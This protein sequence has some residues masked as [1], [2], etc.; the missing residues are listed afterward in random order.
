MHWA[1]V[2]P[3]AVFWLPTAQMSAPMQQPPQLAG[4]QPGCGVHTPE[5]HVSFG[6]QL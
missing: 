2:T 4:L 6:L 3:H 5:E 1:P